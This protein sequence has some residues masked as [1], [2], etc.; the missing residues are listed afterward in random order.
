MF[1]LCPELP[2]TRQ[3]SEGQSCVP[4]TVSESLVCQ[5]TPGTGPSAFSVQFGSVPDSAPQAAKKTCCR[6]RL[7]PARPHMARLM[8]F[9][10]LI[11]PSTG[12]VLQ[13]SFSAAR[14]ASPSRL[15][16]SANPVSAKPLAAASQPSSISA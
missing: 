11:C 6:S 4:L 16:P 14:T 13:G 5:P 2:A 3:S 15:I 9:K 7:K 10:R 1:A 12:P 8:V